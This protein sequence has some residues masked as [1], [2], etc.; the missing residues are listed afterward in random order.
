M[1]TTPSPADASKSSASLKEEFTRLMPPFL[2]TLSEGAEMGYKR[3]REESCLAHEVD[4]P[5]V[6]TS[7]LGW[8][9]G[10]ASNTAAANQS[11]DD[12]EK[13]LVDDGWEKENEIEKPDTDVGG[14]RKLFFRKSD[15]GITTELHRSSG[16][17]TLDI[18]LTS[19]CVDQPV[20][21][22]MQRSELDPGY[23]KS[24]QYYDDWK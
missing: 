2:T 10:E 14:V 16:Q 21:H 22:R 4:N 12:L 24:S 11:L 13:Q 17:E 6:N 3:V 19:R 23:G 20:E 18:K 8:A 15:L 1:S 5:Q 9:I 7:W